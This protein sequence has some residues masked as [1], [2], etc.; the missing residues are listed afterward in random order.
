MEADLEFYKKRFQNSQNENETLKKENQI[1]RQQLN[2]CKK[3]IQDIAEQKNSV[4]KN[5]STFLSAN[6][7]QELRI[8]LEFQSQRIKYLEQEL[9][10]IRTKYERVI[11][12][13][14]NPEN[15]VRPASSYVSE[16]FHEVLKLRKE[17]LDQKEE[18]D[19]V[20]KNFGREIASLK[21]KLARQDADVIL[22]KTMIQAE[23][24]AQYESQKIRLS[25][26]WSANQ[27]QS[28]KNLIQSQNQNQNQNVLNLNQSQSNRSM[29]NSQNRTINSSKNNLT[30]FENKFGHL[31]N[32]SGNIA[33]NQSKRSLLEQ[34]QQ[35]NNSI[36]NNNNNNSTNQ[37]LNE[38][39]GSIRQSSN[40]ILPSLD[41]SK[42]YRNLN[43]AQ[44]YSSSSQSTTN[45]N[46]VN[47]NIGKLGNIQ[48]INSL[49]GGYT[50]F[51]NG[52]Y[53]RFL[54]KIN[55]DGNQKQDDK[56]GNQY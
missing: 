48:A 56:K 24:E 34:S 11:F 55:K 32:Q 39:S 30:A 33:Q 4:N 10:N 37:S 36:N 16:N 9:I 2:S 38:T 40:K 46:S 26:R 54:K 28:N 45:A 50:P 52:E 22:N 15:G 42:I 19:K 13:N 35:Q 14:P 5:Q 29:N 41:D 23:Q 51:Q 47:Q 49:S 31:Y 17:N 7:E 1:L 21:Q 8:V 44:K 53:D 3:A 12:D 27:K 43:L 20:V 25:Q 18:W 6:T